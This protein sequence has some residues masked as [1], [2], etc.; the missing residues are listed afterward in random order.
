MGQD[1]DPIINQEQRRT[2]LSGNLVLPPKWRREGPPIHICLLSYSSLCCRRRREHSRSTCLLGQRRQNWSNP[3][4]PRHKACSSAVKAAL[5][6]SSARVV[7]PAHL[8]AWAG[9]HLWVRPQRVST[10]QTRS[11]TYTQIYSVQTHTYSVHSHP[12]RPQCKVLVLHISQINATVMMLSEAVFL[13]LFVQTLLCVC[14]C[15]YRHSVQ[16]KL[17]R[18]VR[19]PGHRDEGHPG[20]SENEGADPEGT[21]ATSP[22]G[23]GGKAVRPQFSGPQQLQN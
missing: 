4:H 10:S 17:Y 6:V 16:P 14:V 7:S 2:V 13:I 19:R 22:A 12:G 15:A 8:E 9:A 5:T 21:A 20:G 18:V 23:H 1:R 3:P 11:H